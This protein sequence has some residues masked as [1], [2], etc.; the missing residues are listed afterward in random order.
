MGPEQKSVGQ[1]ALGSGMAQQGARTLQG[2]PYQRH[3][4]EAKAMGQAP[5]TPEQFL[6][7]SRG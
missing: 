6:T 2:I 7:Q 4:Q 3:V 1:K 5:M